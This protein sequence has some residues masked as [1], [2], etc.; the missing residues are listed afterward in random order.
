VPIIAFTANAIIGTDEKFLSNGFDGFI[1]KPIDRI[2]LDEILNK[3]V[4]DCR[5]GETLPT[6][7]E[8][9]IRE[10]SGETAE[11]RLFEDLSA[12]GFDI[13]KGLERY[14]DESS[15]LGVLRSYAT[16]TPELLDRM[17]TCSG[18]LPEYAITVHGIK[19]ASAGICAAAVAAS[20]A[21]LEGLAKTGDMESVLSRNA[22]FIEMA[23][24]LICEIGETLKV[25][26]SRLS[27][28]QGDHRRLP[29][30]DGALLAEMLYGATRMLTSV[31]ERALSKLECH[32]YDSGGELVTWL[33]ER[34]EDLDYTA[35]RERL[36][37]M[38]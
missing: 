2:R 35:I 9:T 32:D 13:A 12:S 19:G 34:L 37:N 36:E 4:R 21:E 11:T 6:A 33:R 22:T 3:W 15:Y 30:P 8:D 28:Q 5:T 1:S 17:A 16:H 24:K 25:A 14:G 23:R 38:I 18:L 27:A 20:A 10:Q 29:S 7:E 26:S 31:M